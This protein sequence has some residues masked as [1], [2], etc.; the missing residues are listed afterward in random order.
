L[1]KKGSG[2]GDDWGRAEQLVMLGGISGESG[3][4]KLCGVKGGEGGGE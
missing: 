2:E 4:K 3:G 1:G